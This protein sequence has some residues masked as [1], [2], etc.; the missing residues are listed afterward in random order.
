M[1]VYQSFLS[2][3]ESQNAQHQLLLSFPL[4]CIVVGEHCIRASARHSQKTVQNSRHSE[5]VSLRLLGCL[6]E[7]RTESGQHRWVSVQNVISH[8]WH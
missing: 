1:N 7:T 5:Q 8:R 4:Y 2:I 3:F 6:G